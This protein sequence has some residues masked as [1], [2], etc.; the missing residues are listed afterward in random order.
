MLMPEPACRNTE[1]EK[2]GNF[3]PG[4]F[5]VAWAGWRNGELRGYTAYDVSEVVWDRKISRE[6]HRGGRWVITVEG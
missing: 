6:D 4:V 1:T 2:R 3:S 5:T